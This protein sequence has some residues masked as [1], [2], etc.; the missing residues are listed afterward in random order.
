[1]C[2]VGVRCRSARHSWG[3]AAAEAG[4]GWSAASADVAPLAQHRLDDHGRRV[5]GRGLLLE[6]QLELR[7]RREGAVSSGSRARVKAAAGGGVP[8]V[9]AAVRSVVLAF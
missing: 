3:A 4:R 6:Q 1:M 5:G 8:L 9:A 2:W 7:R